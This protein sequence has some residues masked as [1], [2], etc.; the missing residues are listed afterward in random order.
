[1]KPTVGRIV[2]YRVGAADHADLRY[3][4]NQVLPAIVVRVFTDTCI[5]LKIFTDGP[6]DVWKTSVVQGDGEYQWQWPQRA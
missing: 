3:N 5:S 1:M 2:L 6:T 4:G